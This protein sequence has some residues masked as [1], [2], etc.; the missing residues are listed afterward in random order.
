MLLVMY[1]KKKPDNFI[2]DFPYFA[3]KCDKFA[4]DHRW[5]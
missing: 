3:P 5:I 2:G 4:Y 1:V